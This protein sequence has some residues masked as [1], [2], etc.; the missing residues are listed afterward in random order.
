L[1]AIA[2]IAIVGLAVGIVV[3]ATSN[4]R[5]TTRS[6]TRVVPSAISTSAS[7]ESGAKLDHSGRNARPN[8]IYDY[9]GHY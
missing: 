2:A 8:A 4:R 3:L 1:L 7:A 5:V 6:A 9:P